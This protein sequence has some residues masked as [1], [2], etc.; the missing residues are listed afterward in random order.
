MDAE[1]SVHRVWVRMVPTYP[2]IAGIPGNS[3]R[4]APRTRSSDAT[5]AAVDI[6]MQNN[7]MVNVMDNPKTP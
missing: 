2:D 6:S 4:W 3:L 5:A 1:G 7:R